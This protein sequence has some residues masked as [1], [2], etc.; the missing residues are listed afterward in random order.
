M[1]GPTEIGD[2]A[3]RRALAI[4]DH[5]PGML[6]TPDSRAALAAS[7][8][9]A[10]AR[11]ATIVP[12]GLGAHRGI[13]QAPERY[14]V[15][16]STRALARV[17]DYAPADMTVTVESGVTLAALETLL[18]AEGQWLPLL[19]PWPSR[20]TIGGLVAADLS[21]LLRGGQG[22]VRDYVIGV[23][24]V[25]AQGREVRAGGRVV[26]NVAGYDLM[27]LMIGSLGTLAV[28][29]EVTMKVR[30][31]PETTRVIAFACGEREGGL[32]LAVH[33]ANLDEV[34]LAVVLLTGP[35]HDEPALCCIL[36]GVAADVTTTRARVL[37]EMREEATTLLCDEPADGAVAGA[38]VAEARDLARAAA[39][40]IVVRAATLR[41]RGA[42]L[43]SDLLAELAASSALFDPR[44][45]VVTVAVVTADPAGAIAR[46]QAIAARHEATLT[47]ERWPDALAQ[48]IEVWSPLPASLPLMRRI[49]EAL[50]P[51]RTL[52]PGRFVGR[53]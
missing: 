51:A 53:L 33:L 27:K 52:A 47:F 18:A 28:V 16:L 10:A 34:A 36:G 49:K 14:D 37:R 39:G 24:M 31:R 17:V 9:E 40:E 1:S 46:A 2:L 23:A 50:D 30:P 25:T 19:A 21:G 43:A 15:A 48:T 29:T 3:A 5:V 22:R 8:G 35:D 6:V 20:T 13:G 11:G 7:V 45:G 12:L 26:K 41:T 42:A 44:A 4:A 32:R 38:L